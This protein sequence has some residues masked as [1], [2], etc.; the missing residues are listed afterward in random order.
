MNPTDFLDGLERAGFWDEEC[1]AC[2]QTFQDTD[3]D[4]ETDEDLCDDCRD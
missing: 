3:P 1:D 2:G 4:Y